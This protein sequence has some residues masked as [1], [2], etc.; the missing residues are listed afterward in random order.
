[1]SGPTHVLLPYVMKVMAF[2]EAHLPYFYYKF[3]IFSF[4]LRDPVSLAYNF[5][6]YILLGSYI[7]DRKT[8]TSVLNMI[9]E[10]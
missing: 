9:P 3:S 1:M 2:T 7:A 6:H 8:N 4:M 10:S 5:V